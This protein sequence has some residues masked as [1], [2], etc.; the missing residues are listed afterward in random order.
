METKHYIAGFA[1]RRWDVREQGQRAETNKE[2][3]LSA[4]A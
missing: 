4:S 1:G 2:G 3:A